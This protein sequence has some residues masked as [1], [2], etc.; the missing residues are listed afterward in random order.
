M[1]VGSPFAE[2]GIDVQEG[3]FLPAASLIN[4][5][6]RRQPTHELP[7]PETSAPAATGTALVPYAERGVE[8]LIEYWASHLEGQDELPRR[9]DFDRIAR[10]WRNVFLFAFTGSHRRPL[11]ELVAKGTLDLPQF[12]SGD[13]GPNSGLFVWT[14][15]LA[16]KAVATRRPIRK[17]LAVPGRDA[18]DD[19]FVSLVVLPLAAEG[20]DVTQVLCYLHESGADTIA[21]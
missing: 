21:A 9:V 13:M 5:K 11:V 12:A 15:E 16:R 4:I 2:V 20:A 8:G 10:D 6:L 18:R 3:D 7:E 14:V 17:T 19:A 1:S